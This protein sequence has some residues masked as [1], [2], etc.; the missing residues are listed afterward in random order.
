MHVPDRSFLSQR[1]RDASCRLNQARSSTP[2]A[3]QSGTFRRCSVT[4][5]E[6]RWRIR[7][8]AETVSS[9]RVSPRITHQQY[10]NKPYIHRSLGQR[11]HDSLFCTLLRDLC[12]A[13]DWILSLLTNSQQLQNFLSHLWQ[14]LRFLGVGDKEQGCPVNRSA[15]ARAGCWRGGSPAILAVLDEVLPY[16]KNSDSFALSL[17]DGEG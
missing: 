5:R 4:T 17:D 13:R 3:R 15:R 16:P 7:G 9:P 6:A 2:C 8:Y 10:S 14:F 11:D 1:G 12:V